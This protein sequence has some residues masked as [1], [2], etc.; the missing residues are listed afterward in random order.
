MFNETW[1]CLFR[2]KRN[3][4]L[5]V[6]T[7]AGSVNAV[8]VIGALLLACPIAI[9][10]DVVDLDQPPSAGPDRGGNGGNGGSPFSNRYVV[11]FSPGTDHSKRAEAARDAGVQ[12]RH[13]FNFS[14]ALTVVVPNEN[15][16]NS[17][18]N[19]RSVLTVSPE[20]VVRLFAKKPNAPSTLDA[21]ELFPD[22]IRL[23]WMDNSSGNGEEGGFEIQSCSGAGCSPTDPLF[24]TGP[25]VTSYDNGG[26]L[27][28]SYSYRVRATNGGN[29]P[30]SQWSNTATGLLGGGGGQPP[31]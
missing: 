30:S 4:H 27:S 19:N 2:I 21:T 6:R 7:P 29:G 1:S 25:N 31:A 18:R 11:T 13:N 12:V 10:Q 24:T 9:A 5:Q 22:T 8:L 17:L 23:T 26:L 16:L 3:R 15:A 28:G 20:G 14:N